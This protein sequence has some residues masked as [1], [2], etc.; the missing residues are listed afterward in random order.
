[1]EP[2]LTYKG[3]PLTFNIDG[4]STPVSGSFT[5]NHSTRQ[6]EM[7]DG[8]QWVAISSNGVSISSNVLSEWERLGFKTEDEMLCATN[9]GLAELKNAADEAKEKYEAFKALVR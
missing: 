5:Y 2:T 6:F 3:I 9:P 7:F 8:T 1:M 4:T